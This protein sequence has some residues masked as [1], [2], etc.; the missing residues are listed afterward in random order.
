MVSLAGCEVYTHNSK[1]FPS[2]GSGCPTPD[3]IELGEGLG[4]KDPDPHLKQRRGRK[5][6][7]FTFF[8]PRSAKPTH[9]HGPSLKHTRCLRSW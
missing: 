8:T 6:S 5:E 4:R 3:A 1:P 2:Y 7:D 9:A